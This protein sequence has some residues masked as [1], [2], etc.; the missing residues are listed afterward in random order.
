MGVGVCERQGVY[1]VGVFGRVVG[2]RMGRRSRRVT[3]G[4]LHDSLHVLVQDALG[5]VLGNADV[6][7]GGGGHGDVCVVTFLLL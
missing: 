4:R 6:G 3:A 7:G 1:V 5:V 2:V